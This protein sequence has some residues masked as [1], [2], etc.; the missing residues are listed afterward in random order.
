MKK[1]SLMLNRVGAWTASVFAAGI[2]LAACI[3][4]EHIEDVPDAIDFQPVIYSP[5]TRAQDQ[6]NTF[7]TSISFG[8][9]AWIGVSDVT[10]NSELYINNQEVRHANNQW[11]FVNPCYWPMTGYLDFFCYS[12]YNAANP[13]PIVTVTSD[14]NKH[15]IVY[16]NIVANSQTP[17]YMYA[18]KAINQTAETSPNGVA[19]KFNHA[20]AMVKYGIRLSVVDN[21][22]VG[23]DRVSWEVDL[24]KFEITNITNKGSVTLKLSNRN[25]QEWMKPNPAVWKEAASKEDWQLV[26]PSQSKLINS[27]A[28]TVLKQAMVIPQ[29]LEAQMQLTISYDLITKQGT[30]KPVREEKTI[31]LPLNTIESIQGAITRW[32]MN[33]V[34]TYNVVINPPSDL[35]PLTFAP[36]VGDWVNSNS[37]IEVSPN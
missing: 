34:I 19:I 30:S 18:S 36:N 37:S 21:G 11:G 25:K 13:Q 2:L 31:Q 17:D 22:K 33:K 20:L 24:K 27:T 12:P 8:A 23:K 15:K 3:S 29:E 10:A 4:H 1:V 26:K 28:L 35:K 6:A 5:Q 9:Y 7:D 32:E 14:F 16:K